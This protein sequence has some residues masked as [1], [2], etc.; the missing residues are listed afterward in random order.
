MCLQLTDAPA[1]AGGFCVVPGSHKANFPVPPALADLADDE[2]NEHVAQ[3]ALRPG[4]LLLFTE[5]PLQV[6]DSA[7]TVSTVGSLEAIRRRPGRGVGPS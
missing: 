3:P 7:P 2:L 1:G 5:V 6:A 4:D